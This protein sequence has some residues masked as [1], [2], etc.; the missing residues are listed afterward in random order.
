M[1]IYIVR[2]EKDEKTLWGVKKGSRIIPISNEE[3]LQDFIQYQLDEARRKVEEENVESISMDDVKL[4]APVTPKAIICQGVNYS[5][6]R[7]ETGIDVKKPPFNLIFT[8]AISSIT[9]PNDAIVRPEHVKLLDYEIE[10]GLV[11]KKEIHSETEISEENLFDYIL[12]IVIA[13]DI[14]ARDVQFMETQWL[15]GKSYRTFCPV[16]PYLYILD[17]DEIDELFDLNLQL[18]VNGEIRQQASTS[19][20]LYK[21]VETLNELAQMMD[22]SPGD[23]LLTGTP[24]G[25][26]MQF[27]PEEMHMLSSLSTSY[28]KKKEILESV[29]STPYLQEGDVIEAKI[30]SSKGIDLGRQRNVVVLEK[31]A[32]S[33]TR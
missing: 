23:L 25:V 27:S 32:Y 13:N 20:L 28:E 6:H 7:E 29:D 3:T 21:P 11:L 19:Q 15:K 26:A 24:G 12:G 2:F 33:Q 14:S 18:T 8:K 1:G 10:L 30:F 4:L 5:H 31:K 17:Q 9:G 22:L 16:G